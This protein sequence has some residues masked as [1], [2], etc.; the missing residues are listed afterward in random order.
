MTP[1]EFVVLV[2]RMRDA[3]R[4]YFRTRDPEVL[5]RSKYLERQVDRAIKEAGQPP[6]P[7]EPTL[8]PEPPDAR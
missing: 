7:P 6:R 4:E 8:F 1:E 3:Q 2:G 5:N